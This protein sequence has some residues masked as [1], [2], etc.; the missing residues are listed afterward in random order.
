MINWNRVTELRDEIGA[1]DF[2][3]ITDLFLAEVEE[4]IEKLRT[5]PDLGSLGEDLHFLKGCALNL[6]FQSFS[7]HCQTGETLSGEGLAATVEIPIIITC[8]DESKAN[9]LAS[10]ETQL[11][12]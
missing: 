6:G 11:S 10:L 2:A 4:V 1:E 9:F 5:T 8:Y 12:A 3:E 7:E